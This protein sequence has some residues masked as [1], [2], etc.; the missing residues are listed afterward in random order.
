MKPKRFPPTDPR[1]WLRRARSN[2]V[3]SRAEA[4]EVDLAELC[5]DAQQAAE[6][7][8]K[9]VFI[10]RGEAF[11]FTH[12]LEALVRRLKVNGQKVPKYVEAAKVLTRFAV[13]ARYPD[14]TTVTRRKYG[15]SV[16]IASA[17]L[18]W[19]ERQI[20]PPSKRSP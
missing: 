17:V 6:E 2:L 4:D 14:F 8:I 3:H 5:F 11:P 9:A 13:V 20:A 19:A 15:R 18:R 7:A 10:H 16:R 12:D 1:E